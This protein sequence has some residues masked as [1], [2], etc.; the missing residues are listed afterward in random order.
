MLGRCALK[1]N[2]Q[3]G[4]YAVNLTECAI[5]IR[6]PTKTKVP[7]HLCSEKSEAP[8]AGNEF[9]PSCRHSGE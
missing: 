6:S 1:E 5:E 3:R 9:L 4:W 8:E 7:P 2:P